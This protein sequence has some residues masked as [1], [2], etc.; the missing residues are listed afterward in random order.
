MTYIVMS[1]V[2]ILVCHSD[3]APL[4]RTEAGGE[5][6]SGSNTAHYNKATYARLKFAL[7]RKALAGSES[8]WR[9]PKVLCSASFFRAVALSLLPVI[10]DRKTS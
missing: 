3:S 2:L 10:L 6:E 8:N 1:S 4:R 7:A 9:L 5:A